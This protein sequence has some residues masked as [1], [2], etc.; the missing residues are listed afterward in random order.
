M[1]LLVDT[2]KRVEVGDKHMETNLF[3]YKT[4]EYLV[5]VNDLEITHN[6]IWFKV[7]QI[8]LKIHKTK[9]MV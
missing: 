9:Q 1:L 2:M 6:F 5:S 8:M 7:T 4:N 3:Q